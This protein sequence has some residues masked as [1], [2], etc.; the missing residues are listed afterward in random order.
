MIRKSL[1]I[2]VAS[3]LC[4]LCFATLF[5][6]PSVAA[7]Q[8]QK[9]NGA[10]TE[11]RKLFIKYCASCH[12]EDAK[13]YGPVSGQLKTLPADLTRIPLENGK[14]P[15]YKIEET[16][17]GE[18]MTTAHGTR[19]MP[20]WGS[21]IRRKGEGMLRLELYNLTKYLESIQQK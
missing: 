21:I 19:E 2:A 18:H 13:G 7:K 10:P 11:G 4:T 20:V 5:D 14:F 15:A 17:T 9:K 8:G 16:I 12:G 1:S 3:L 6:S